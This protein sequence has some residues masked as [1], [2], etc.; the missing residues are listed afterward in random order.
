MTP[1]ATRVVVGNL[2]F[3]SFMELWILAEIVEDPF[4]SPRVQG[5]VDNIFEI[6]AE[7]MSRGM[8][9]GW[10]QLAATDKVRHIQLT[11]V[12]IIVR[13]LLPCSWA[14]TL[15]SSKE[16]RER[17]RRILDLLKPGYHLDYDLTARLIR[18]IYDKWDLDDGKNWTNLGPATGN[19]L[20]M[21]KE[22]G[23]QLMDY[24]NWEKFLKQEGLYVPFF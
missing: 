8:Y 12:V 9:S 22:D 19:S 3:Q 2:L 7:A 11:L 4:S 5:A 13:F 15:A 17:S 6:V 18:T 20:L 1:H 23:G 21:G 24:E 10:V 14:A 16:S